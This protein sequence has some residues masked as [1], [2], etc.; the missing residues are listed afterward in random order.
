MELISIDTVHI[1]ILVL[2]GFAAG[3]INTLAGGGSNLSLPALMMFGL[4]ADVANATNRVSVLLQSL[5]AARGFHKHKSIPPAAVKDTFFPLL[6]GG[7]LGALFASY[8]EVT[9]LK[10][11]LLGTMVAVSLWVVL[12][13]DTKN[14]GL[15]KRKNCWHSP[16]AFM[17]TLLAGFYGGFVQAGVGFVLLA[18]FVGVLN[19]DLLKA[20]ALKVVATLIFTAI[21]LLVFIARDQVAWLPGLILAAGSM[22]GAQVAVKF[23]IAIKPKTLKFLVLVMTI[24]ASLAALLL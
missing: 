15:E 8:L 22:L 5:T 13:S 1:L 21:A 16:K 12:R 4:P 6:L 17:S 7:L 24:V 9:V 10:P 23:A 14:I 3:V 11:L 20:N 18:V 2:T 19:Y